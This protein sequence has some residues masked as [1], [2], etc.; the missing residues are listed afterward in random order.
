MV[1]ERGDTVAVDD[2]AV[3]EAKEIGD[4]FVLVL[5]VTFILADARTGVLDD[6]RAFLDVGGGVNASAWICEERTM[7][8]MG[9]GR[10]F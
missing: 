10:L 8:A 9:S 2:A 5:L 1:D 7:R 6:V 4:V 3:V